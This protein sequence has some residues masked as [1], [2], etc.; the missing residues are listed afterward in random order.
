V[1]Q[2]LHAIIVA[3]VAA[4]VLISRAHAEAPWQPETNAR[5]LTLYATVFKEFGAAIRVAP[6]ADAPAMFNTTCGGIWPVI[7]VEG[8]WVKIRTEVGAGWIGGGRVV[9]STLPR[10][11]D[12][13]GERFLYPTAE[14]WTYSP[15]GCLSLQSR[16][17]DEAS[18]I[19]C[20]GNGHVYSVV[21]GPF[22]PGTGQDWFKVTS[23][24]TGT[25]WAPAEH[26]FPL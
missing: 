3:T 25:G 7:V 19:S 16:P 26:L 13:S 15:V 2:F 14:A 1:R 12:C 18:T 11:V 6:A 21:D 10:S 17:T 23:P 9:V 22:D 8:G 5:G 24:T 20:V 4:A